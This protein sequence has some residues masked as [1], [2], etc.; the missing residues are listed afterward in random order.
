MMNLLKK[1][2]AIQITDT[3]NLVRKTDCH[4]KIGE[5]EKKILDHA[6][7]KYITIQ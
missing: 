7:A 6:H 3:S 5:N 2:N 4:A 1:V